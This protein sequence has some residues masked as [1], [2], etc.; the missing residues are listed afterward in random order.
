MIYIKTINGRQIFSDCR[1]IQMSNGTWVSNPTAEQIA[2]A[3]WTEYIP[4]EVIPTPQTEPDYEQVMQAVKTM[5]STSVENLSDEDALAVA[6]LYPTWISKIGEQVNV[7]ERYWYDGKLY[8]V[9]QAH[10]AQEDWTPDVSV[11]LFT[12]ISVEEWP[13]W[14]QPTGAQDAYMQGDKV[15]HNGIH[16]VSTVDNNVWE[17]GVYGWSQQ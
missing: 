10:T 8:K 16:W 1:T 9:I 3:G 13:E 2:E 15:S 5:L 7:G 6:A 17:P 14:H 4:P 12:K 11:S